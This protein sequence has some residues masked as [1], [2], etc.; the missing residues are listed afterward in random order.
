MKVVGIGLIRTGTTT[1][2]ACFRY[3][4]LKHTSRHDEAFELWRKGEYERLVQLIDQ[5]DS[6]EDWPWPLIY[7]EVDNTFHGTK[8]ILTRRKD[9]NTWYKSLCKHANRTGPTDFRKY[10]FGHE[11]PHKHQEEHTRFYQDHLN[12]V[13]KYFKNRPGDLLEVCW[14]E[15][16][17]WDE[18]ATFL[19]FERPNIPFP[20]ANKSL[21]LLDRGKNLTRRYTRQL[22]TLL[23]SR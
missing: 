11:M 7:K 17:G 8:F 22:F 5:Y 1:L 15:G 23:H 14:E 12:S 16:D 3:W 18:L 9:A 10:I 19:G 20:H 6:F 21:T 4:G 13:R 2:G